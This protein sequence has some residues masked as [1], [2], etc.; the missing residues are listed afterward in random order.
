MDRPSIPPKS[1]C[2][3]VQGATARIVGQDR[4]GAIGGRRVV[5]SPPQRRGCSLHKSAGTGKAV[6][7]GD[8]GAELRSRRAT[9]GSPSVVR[10]CAAVAE[11]RRAQVADAE[12]AKKPGQ[13]PRG[14]PN[15]ESSVC[16]AKFF[17]P[18]PAL[19]RAERP[20]LTPEQNA[21]R[22]AL[23]GRLAGFLTRPDVAP[24]R[25]EELDA[26][27]RRLCGLE[28]DILRMDELLRVLR[29]RFLSAADWRELAGLAER[30]EASLPSCRAMASALRDRLD[31]C[32]A[33]SFQDVRL[34]EGLLQQ[35]DAA[36]DYGSSNRLSRQ[37]VVR[38]VAVPLPAGDVSVA[39]VESRVIPGT[40]FGKSLAHG[41]RWDDGDSAVE[42]AVLMH[43]P[44]LAG[45]TLTN[46]RGEVLFSGLR[47]GFI[48]LPQLYRESIE[49]CSDAAL[50]VSDEALRRFSE[51]AVGQRN[52]AAVFHQ[53][54]VDAL[55]RRLRADPLFAKSTAKRWYFRVVDKMAEETDSAAIIADREKFEK[56]LQG[57]TVDVGMFDI[58]LLTS[59]ESLS[60]HEHCYARFPLH[61]VHG[62]LLEKLKLRDSNGALHTAWAR[63]RMRPFAFFVGND[64]PGLWDH[65]LRTAAVGRLL[66]VLEAGKLGGDVMRRVEAMRSEIPKLA[67]EL[68]SAGYDRVRSL[69]APALEQAPRQAAAKRVTR[70]KVEMARLERNARTL[71]QAGRQLKDMWREHGEWPTGEAAYQ[72]ASRLALV[73]YLMGETPILSCLSGRDF[74][75]RLDAETKILAA[76]ADSGNGHL[77]P[78]GL[79]MPEWDRSRDALRVDLTTERRA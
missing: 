4:P 54:T 10:P 14:K 64:R 62:T 38:R 40:A 22:P 46:A 60:L 45:T 28:R 43:V 41:Y 56:A 30:T 52:Q 32:Q 74:S 13:D 31:S 25:V 76:V 68:A 3:N 36:C 2:G 39:V 53:Q 65:Q 24:E 7:V 1:A 63:V 29:S 35:L 34:Y 72:A 20:W 75:R 79:D 16:A 37:D 44:E 19:G 70:L 69:P 73:G 55:R 50:R 42:R 59:D 6:A 5:E 71:E 67:R 12:T 23:Q 18:V 77:P 57:W 49:Q 51:M 33:I 66:G 47:S 17:K 9:I 21:D 78:V 15:A 61:M 26:A 27:C 48:G 58:A 11:V 8:V